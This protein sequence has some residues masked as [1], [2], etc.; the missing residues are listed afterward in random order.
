MEEHISK[1]KAI[2]MLYDWSNHTMTDA[3]TWHLRQV[4]GDIKSMPSALIQCKNCK[5]SEEYV[6]KC[7]TYYYCRKHGLYRRTEKDF[8]S[9]AERRGEGDE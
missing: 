3:E 9:Q 4:I 1:L 6:P 8:C 5:W 2:D 7:K